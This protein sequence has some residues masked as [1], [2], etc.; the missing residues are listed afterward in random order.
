MAEEADAQAT[1]SIDLEDNTSGAAESAANALATLQ[2]QIKGDTAELANM[3]R[4]MKNL[5]GGTSVNIEQFKKLRD[6]IDAK[7]S[8]IA[9][10][11]SAYI[12]LGGNFAKGKQGAQSFSERL[13]ALG[14]TAKGMPGPLGG[15]V[16]SLESLKGL[17]GGGALALGVVALSAALVALAAAAVLAMGAL[18][19]YGVAQANARRGELLQLEGLTKMRNWY[20]LAAGNA[21]EMQSAID[22]VSGSTAL[23]REKLAGYTGELYKMGLRGKNLELALEGAAIKG[24][25]LGDEGAKSFMHWAAG[26]NMAGQS[27]KRLTDDV[28]ARF[29]GVA[30][31]QLLD[32]NVQTEKLRENFGQLFSNLHIEELLKGLAS[33][34]ALFS[35]STMTGRAL[36]NIVSLMLQPL[37][38][39]T[40]AAAP[41][42]KRFFQGLVIGAL[43]VTI[44]VLQVR[45]WFRQTFGDS[46]VLKGMDLQKAALYAGIT[47]VG[48][49]GV[50]FVAMGALV[51][52]A[53]AA[54]MPFIWAAVTAVGALAVSGLVLA[55]PFILG[56]IAIG[57]LVAAGLA[58]Y[59]LWK[60]VD[61]T[62][63]GS[64][65]V[66]GIVGGVKSGAKWVIDAVSDLGAN[67]MTALK[68]KL[69]IASPSKAFA[70]LGLAIPE[71]LESGVEAGTPAAKGAVGRMVDVPRIPAAPDARGGDARAPAG[72][73]PSSIT[74]N[75]GG[76]TITSAATS[77]SELADG[78][79][80]EL[81][82]VL[83][84]VAAQL[85]AFVPRGAS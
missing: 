78:L 27:V 49:F 46:E 66:D 22:A 33:I 82:R 50:A 74:L 34:T 1:Y 12:N 85:G 17:L 61:W 65:I 53:L 83:E 26:A 14:V 80:R 84:N 77:A 81:T 7:K 70:R 42:M 58:L 31:A 55:A 71:G 54:A 75:L 25:V 19:K 24:A 6:Q 57:A 16:G 44:A 4:A 51:V 48:L 30:A 63:L 60:E 73:K 56:A 47:A 35:Q 9:Q 64:A 29:G 28:K 45:K 21:G 10:A 40:T 79:E 32:L 69:G 5:Q 38:D 72:A 36:R 39:A 13:A 11:Q 23:G 15:M 37:I 3:Q 62:E 67:A 8:A 41:V 76:I 20:G 2:K 52:G 43:L 59:D 68:E 18:L